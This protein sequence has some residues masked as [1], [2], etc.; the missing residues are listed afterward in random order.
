MV[1]AASVALIALAGPFTPVGAQTA[2]P[3]PFPRPLLAFVPVPASGPADPA[4][5]IQT[6]AAGEG[7]GVGTGG[8]RRVTVGFASS[9]TL[10]AEPYRV[11]VVWGN[12]GGAQTRAS[13]V[14][15]V[16]STSGVVETSTDGRTWKDAGATTATFTD[17]AV[18]IDAALGDAA[19]GTGLW[20]QAQLGQDAA[21]LVTTP[22]FSLDAVVGR[23]TDGG[24]PAT[25]WGS[26][27]VAAGT[28]PATTSAS[29][30]AFGTAVPTLTVDNQALIVTD[31]S[32][33]PTEVAGQAVTSVVDEVTFMSGYTPSGTVS[34]VVQIDRTAGTIRA[35]SG[36]TG[37]PEDRTG[38]GSWVV[39]GLAAPPASSTAPVTVT[40]DLVGVTKALGVPLDAS[41]TGLGLRR[42]VA[43]ADGSVVVG[44]PVTAT[45]GWFQT[46]A[47][48]TEAPPGTLALEVAASDAASNTSNATT[49]LVAAGVVVVVLVVVALVF[50]VRRRRRVATVQADLFGD[51]GVESPPEVKAAPS[52]FG[53]EAPVSV[54]V[55]PAE[56]VIPPDQAD[57]EHDGQAD[58]ED[59]E[60]DEH[61]RRP[62]GRSPADVLAAL[63]A[64]V[65][66]LSAR[67]ERLGR[68]DR[69]VPPAGGPSGR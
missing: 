49:A 13:L 43:L 6:V 11:S 60:S 58:D 35:L 63:D 50:M 7:S 25:S 19:N 36:S 65:L 28:N 68:P 61:V 14:S 40:L 10:P 37:L 53:R 18:A 44:L 67:V 17:D 29:P 8:D 66:D 42:K 27:G 38:S 51:A 48:P 39:K 62:G 52:L 26:T 20:V 32:A 64:E 31:P 56:A 2:A 47:V 33:A 21:R 3:T 45:V 4:L 34:G 15:S 59:A 16:G 55:E 24:L 12:P 23:T 69:D 57:E 46:A 30:V 1:L 54:P 9:F 41:G 22:V 5:A